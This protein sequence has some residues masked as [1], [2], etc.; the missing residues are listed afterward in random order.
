MRSYDS[1]TALERGL[2]SYI[3]FYN[4]ERPHTALDQRTP[5][6]VHLRLLCNG[7]R[8]A[9]ES[10]LLTWSEIRGPLH[11]PR[12]VNLLLCDLLQGIGKITASG[13]GRKWFAF[14]VV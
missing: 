2:G 8:I 6:E 3:D 5:A 4:T 13:R 7:P 11:C 1:P 14:L 10:L 9:S 12:P